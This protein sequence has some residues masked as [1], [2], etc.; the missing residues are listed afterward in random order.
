MPSLPKHPNLKP[1]GVEPLQ[2]GSLKPTESS[3]KTLPGYDELSDTAKKTVYLIDKDG[4]PTGMDGGWCGTYSHHDSQGPLTKLLKTLTVDERSA[5]LNEVQN[6]YAQDHSDSTS[7]NDLMNLMED[8]LSWPPPAPQP[9]IPVIVHPG[10][11]AVVTIPL[12]PNNGSGREEV[13]GASD[14]PVENIETAPSETPSVSVAATFGLDSQQIMEWVQSDIQRQQAMEAGQAYPK[15][16]YTIDLNIRLQQ[17][18]AEEKDALYESVAPMLDKLLEKGGPSATVAQN[19]INQ[20]Q[21]P[22]RPFPFG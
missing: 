20:L 19:Y 22:S 11:G 3:D 16:V 7:R 5:L 13:T 15:H 17:M 6:Y 1:L 4:T 9:D 12:F 14:T 2:S 8:S 18:S 10:G 21:P